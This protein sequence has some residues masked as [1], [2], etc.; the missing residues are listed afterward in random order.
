MALPI[1]TKGFSSCD[2]SLVSA[3]VGAL[4][5]PAFICEYQLF[6]LTGEATEGEPALFALYA[7][8]MFPTLFWGDGV[9]AGILELNSIL[10]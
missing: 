3:G 4:K 10:R 9:V 5:V 8:I 7:A 1:L 2:A 6:W